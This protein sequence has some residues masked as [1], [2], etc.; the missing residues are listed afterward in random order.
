MI[1]KMVREKHQAYFLSGTHKAESLISFTKMPIRPVRL[2]TQASCLS[3][4]SIQSATAE[5]DMLNRFVSIFL[6]NNLD[7]R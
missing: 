2:D 7:T 3:V 5:L 1:T 6:I 4:E